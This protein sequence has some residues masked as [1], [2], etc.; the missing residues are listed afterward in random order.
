MMLVKETLRSEDMVITWADNSHTFFDNRLVRDI[1]ISHVQMTKSTAPV[2]QQLLLVASL[3]NFTR[4]I[5]GI[6]H[7]VKEVNIKDKGSTGN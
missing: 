6:I 4:R 7:R 5:V 2:E 1:F 3:F